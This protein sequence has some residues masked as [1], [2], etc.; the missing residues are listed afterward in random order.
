MQPD[1][2]AISLTVLFLFTCQIKEENLP[3]WC[4]ILSVRIIG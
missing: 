4:H 1:G 2:S 3:L